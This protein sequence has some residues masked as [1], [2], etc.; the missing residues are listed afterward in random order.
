MKTFSMPNFTDEILAHANTTFSTLH[1]KFLKEIWGDNKT[2][3]KLHS[4]QVYTDWQNGRYE[5]YIPTR[6]SVDFNLE[7]ARVAIQVLPMVSN[8]SKYQ[9]AYDLSVPIKTPLGKIESEFLILIAPRQ[10]RWG[11]VKGFKHRAKPGYFTGIFVNGSADICWKRVLDQ[12]TNFFEKRLNGLFD[13]LGFER[14]VWKW[15]QAKEPTLLYYS[16][17][18]E[19]FSVVIQQSAFTFI[20]LWQHFIKQMKHV[21]N[22]IGLQ[23][24]AKQAISPLLSLNPVDLQR[25]FTYIR[26]DLQVNLE[27]S[28]KQFRPDELKLLQVL[29]H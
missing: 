22:E 5:V 2:T 4:N 26:E 3:N 9:E 19:H 8:D 16:R 28:Q 18:L 20:N 21:L 17:I 6:D 27:Q 7:Y 15:L 29:R 10:D 14:W 24:I 13:S 23:S 25:A 11:L 1:K 12:I